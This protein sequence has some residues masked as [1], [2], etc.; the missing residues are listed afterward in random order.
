MKSHRMRGLI[1]GLSVFVS[2]E[3]AFGA[4][5]ILG[6]VSPGS[7]AIDD[8]TEEVDQWGEDDSEEPYSG[9][10]PPLPR[11]PQDD[12]DF[13]PLNPTEPASADLAPE[14]SVSGAPD[15]TR[16]S[17]ARRPKKQ[18]SAS[19]SSMKKPDA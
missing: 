4:R 12:E 8:R 1:W 6:Q 11:S 2:V 18:V 14:S 5:T 10:L 19:H 15:R 17:A 9:D 7:G 3:F 16:P 13:R